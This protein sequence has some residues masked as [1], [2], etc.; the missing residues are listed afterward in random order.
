MS[1]VESLGPGDFGKGTKKRLPICFC[2]DVSG[3]MQGDRIASL[4]NALKIYFSTIAVNAD[5]VAS[6]DVAIV[7]YGGYVD[8]LQ[9][10][11]PINSIKE[12]PEVVVRPRSF[13]PMG[14]GILTSLKLLELRKQ[15]YKDRGMKYYQPW[16]VLITDG[17]PEGPDADVHFQEALFELNKLEREEK[18]VVFNIGVSDD[19][20]MESL[21]KVSIK[22]SAPI[23]A[24]GDN[25]KEYFQFLGSSSTNVVKGGETSQLYEE[26]VQ[27]GDTDTQASTENGP[28]SGGI[29]KPDDDFDI[30]KWCI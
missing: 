13:T 9:K 6:V 26:V 4:N 24:N 1:S 8:V 25:L 22:R 7:T 12:V 3:S 2:L 21:T 15:G 20:D 11:S 27:D 17:K 5:A 30:D 16:L 10:F 23:R 18:M 29:T 19:A 14:E 28:D